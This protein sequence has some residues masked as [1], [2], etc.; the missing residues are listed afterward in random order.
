MPGLDFCKGTAELAHFDQ[1]IN[2]GEEALS[3]ELFKKKMISNIQNLCF[4]GKN[5]EFHMVKI[6][7][8]MPDGIP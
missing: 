5:K 2:A 1:Y 8:L 6:P 7:Q 4:E 3:P